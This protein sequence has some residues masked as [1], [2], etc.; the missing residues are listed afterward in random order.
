MFRLLR[1]GI[2]LGLKW[3]KRGGRNGPAPTD[4]LPNGTLVTEDDIPMVSENGFYFITED[5]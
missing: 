5:A 1:L 2:G 4:A 3:T